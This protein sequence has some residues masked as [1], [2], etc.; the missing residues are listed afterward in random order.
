MIPVV[1]LGEVL[2]HPNHRPWLHGDLAE[3][4]VRGLLELGHVVHQL[5][6]SAGLAAF[7]RNIYRMLK[8]ST[9]S[10]GMPAMLL[11]SAGQYSNRL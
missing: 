5:Y 4:L 8:R 1:I 2:A 9:K 11:E 10:W 7:L 3:P 6:I